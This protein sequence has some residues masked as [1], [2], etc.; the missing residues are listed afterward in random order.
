MTL[1]IMLLLVTPKFVEVKKKDFC[2]FNGFL[3]NASG[4]AKILSDYKGLEAKCLLDKKILE[5]E[6]KIKINNLSDKYKVQLNIIDDKYKK[7]LKNKDNEIIKLKKN[8]NPKQTPFFNKSF[9][10]GL[11]I[12]IISTVLITYGTMKMY[13]EIK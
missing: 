12:G 5:K 10:W 2:P 8:Y 3:F 9:Y 1:L 7:L 13:S 4:M 6:H 11:G